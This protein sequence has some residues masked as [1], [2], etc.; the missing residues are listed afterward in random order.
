MRIHAN[1]L[2]TRCKV[3]DLDTGRDLRE[4][5]WVDCEVGTAEAFNI[6]DDAPVQFRQGFIHDLDRCF[7]CH[8][9]S[10]HELALNAFFL[11]G[12]RNELPAPMDQ[13]R[14]DPDIAHEH[15]VLKHHVANFRIGEGRAAIF[16]QDLF[17]AEF[18]DVRKRLDQGLRFCDIFL[19]KLRV[20]G[21]DQDV[22]RRE[23]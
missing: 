23:V 10:V 20:R 21:V 16:D 13:D 15:K 3:H 18:L 6:V 19:H 12:I 5:V 14:T 1:Q 22:F 8:A 7:V 2:K 9:E 4:V 11:H 17:A